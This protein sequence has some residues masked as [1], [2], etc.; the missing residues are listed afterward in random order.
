MFNM[1]RSV[2]GCLSCRSMLDPNTVKSIRPHTV[3]QV[4]ANRNPLDKFKKVVLSIPILA[5]V[6]APRGSFPGN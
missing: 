6:D 4:A 5:L 1:P 2:L 3:A